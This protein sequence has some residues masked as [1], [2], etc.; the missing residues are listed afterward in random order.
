LNQA[1]AANGILASGLYHPGGFR[2]DHREGA[3]GP[4]TP[5]T[6]PA[7]LASTPSQGFGATP[8]A[9]GVFGSFQYGK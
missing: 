2:G 8:G 9:G 5:T 7:G 3:G 1:A 4:S 6:N